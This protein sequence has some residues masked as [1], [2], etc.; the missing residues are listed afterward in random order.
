M[1]FYYVYNKYELFQFHNQ[2]SN[3]YNC[4]GEVEGEAFDEAKKGGIVD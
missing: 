1:L 2:S 4:N 3:I